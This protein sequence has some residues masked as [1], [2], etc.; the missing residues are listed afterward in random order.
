[1]AEKSFYNKLQ[2]DEML[3]NVKS[4][5]LKQIEESIVMGTTTSE[6]PQ[7]ADKALTFTIVRS[8]KG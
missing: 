4:Q 1:M 2:V 7:A 6:V 8:E 3:G 5:L